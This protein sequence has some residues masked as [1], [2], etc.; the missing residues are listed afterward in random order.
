M[1][2]KRFF[3]ETTFNVGSGKTVKFFLSHQNPFLNYFKKEGYDKTHGQLL[4]ALFDFGYENHIELEDDEADYLAD[5]VF[6][7]LLDIKN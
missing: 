5:T 4:N 3:K 6:M 1:A 7:D 2:Y